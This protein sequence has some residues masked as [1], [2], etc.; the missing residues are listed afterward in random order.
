MAA[1]GATGFALLLAYALILLPFTPSISDIR[2]AKA[3]T[4]SIL[5]SADGKQLA[6][7]KR[8]NRQWVE[9]DQISPHVINALIATEDH[10]F[11]E[12]H[13]V[14]L[15]RTAAGILRTLQGDP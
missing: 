6:V 10:R 11:Y 8:V 9:L 1:A 15:R 5:M 12:H 7:F 13:G 14:D 4:P 2:K 3:E